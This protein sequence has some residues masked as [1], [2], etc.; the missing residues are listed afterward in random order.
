M[1]QAPEGL[2]AGIEFGESDVLFRPVAEVIEHHDVLGGDA[3]A[4][5]LFL[6]AGRAHAIAVGESAGH[7]G[8]AEDVAR[9]AS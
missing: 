6:A 5:K 2:D 4:E 8:L 3:F 7:G 9:M 1:E